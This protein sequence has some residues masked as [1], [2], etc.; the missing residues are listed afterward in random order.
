MTTE[1]ILQSYIPPTG[2]AIVSGYYESRILAYVALYRLMDDASLNISFPKGHRFGKGDLLTIHLDNRTG[3]DEFDAD[4]R[5]SRSSYKGTV[6]YVDG[7]SIGVVPDEYKLYYSSN[8]LEEYRTP[9]FRYDEVRTGRTLPESG[10]QMEDLNWNKRE[11]ENKL[12]VLMTRLEKR[13]HTSLMAFLSNEED[14]IFLISLKETFKS[15]LLHWDN[16]CCFA[17]DHRAEF[18]FEKAYDWN[19]TI[20]E[21]ETFRISKENPVYD[22]IQYRFVMKNPWETSFFTHPD[23]EMYHIKPRRILVPDTI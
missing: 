9:Q 19:Y 15:K 8:C 4:L 6:S 13:P 1:G 18:I 5:V 12:G 21:G 16:R 2:I 23:I 10:I 3:V 17:I 7:N 20:I 22:E 11:F 14:D